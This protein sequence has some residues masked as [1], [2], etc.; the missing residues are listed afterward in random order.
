[1]EPTKKLKDFIEV[2][3][4]IT[5]DHHLPSSMMQSFEEDLVANDI[6]DKDAFIKGMAYATIVYEGHKSMM[7][8]DEDYNDYPII[9]TIIGFVT[10][11]EI[12]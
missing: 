8:K 9:E 4:E 3:K 12:R 1:M 2:C 5:K 10:R 6:K 11:D 7:M